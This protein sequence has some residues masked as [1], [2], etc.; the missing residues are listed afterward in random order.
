MPQ[1]T[2][3]SGHWNSERKHIWVL[4]TC[5]SCQ[6]TLE[7]STK[8]FIVVGS[9]FE[10]SHV[11]GYYFNGSSLTPYR[12]DLNMKGQR[13]ILSLLSDTL[14]VNPTARY[15][16]R[17]KAAGEKPGSVNASKIQAQRCLLCMPS[18]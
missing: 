11:E 16:R 5:A 13:A 6:P 4:G 14:E 9:S 7:G 1:R 18:N 17:P 8:S 12:V 10:D 15:T 3:Y 2:N